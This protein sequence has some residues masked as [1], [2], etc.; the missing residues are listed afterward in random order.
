MWLTEHA[1]QRLQQRAIPKAALEL[2]RRY[3]RV[4][5]SNGSR[6]RYFDRRSWWQLVQAA[7][8]QIKEPERLSGLYAIE[9]QTGVIVTAGHRNRRIKRDYQPGRRQAR[10]R[11]QRSHSLQPTR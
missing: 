3:G 10:R 6:I 1:T 5:H 11:S 7:G 2:L 8:G 4:E 9:T